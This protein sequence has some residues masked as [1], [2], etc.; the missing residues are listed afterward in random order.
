MNGGIP[1]WRPAGCQQFHGRVRLCALLPETPTP[2]APAR[3]VGDADGSFLRRLVVQEAGQRERGP[4]S[5]YC[6]GLRVQGPGLTGAR[7]AAGRPRSWDE[8]GEGGAGLSGR[9]TRDTACPT[10]QKPRTSLGPGQVGPAKSSSPTSSKPRTL[11]LNPTPQTPNQVRLD[12]WHHVRRPRGRP[13]QPNLTFSRRR[14][15]QVADPAELA[16]PCPAEWAGG[17]GRGE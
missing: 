11:E 10:T 5:P 8:W 7:G 6:F 16:S 3:Q 1:P 12:V 9:S 14:H 4:V 2:A 15:P 13:L 17:G